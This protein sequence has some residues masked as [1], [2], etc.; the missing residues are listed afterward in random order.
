[1]RSSVIQL[2]FVGEITGGA[3]QVCETVTVCVQKMTL[4]REHTGSPKTEL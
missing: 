2:R 4:G 3:V 1:M